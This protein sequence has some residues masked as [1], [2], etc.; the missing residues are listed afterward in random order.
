MAIKSKSTSHKY[1]RGCGEKGTL[2]HWCWENKL[3]QPLWKTV[4]R[5]LKIKI[6]LL[7]ATDFY[8]LILYSAALLNSLIRPSRFLVES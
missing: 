2:I 6:G 5:F 8:M 7:Y 3:M 1:W 4:W